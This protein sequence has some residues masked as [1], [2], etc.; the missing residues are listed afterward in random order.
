MKGGSSLHKDWFCQGIVYLVIRP[1][2]VDSI[3]KRGNT[4]REYVLYIDNI[5]IIA[6]LMFNTQPIFYESNS[7]DKI[8]S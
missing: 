5:R 7:C 8:F 6:F 3:V 1:S 2:L 4:P